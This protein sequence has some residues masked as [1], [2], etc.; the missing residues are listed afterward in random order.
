[1]IDKLAAMSRNS[2]NE[3]NR[4]SLS[5]L[6]FFK[7]ANATS[8]CVTS[9]SGHTMVN[10][11]LLLNWLILE[12]AI[13]NVGILTAKLTE[14]KAIRFSLDA[15]SVSSDSSSRYIALTCKN[16]L[17]PGEWY[18]KRDS[19]GTTDSLM[20]PAAGINPTQVLGKICVKSRYL[21]YAN[22]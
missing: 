7:F 20:R 17:H 22:N 13:V 12:I 3:S 5:T 9:P 8:N 16:L 19:E 10:G 18:H 2:S 6:T 1:M 15:I 21:I 11:G 14:K 4:F